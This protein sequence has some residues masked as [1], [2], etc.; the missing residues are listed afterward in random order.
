MTPLINIFP[1]E[2]FLSWHLF[3]PL[4]IL[5]L[6]LQKCYKNHRAPIFNLHPA[7]PNINLLY[8]HGIILKTKKL[9]FVQYY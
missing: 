5:M 4:F 9:T 8:N 1:R 7:S 2:K 3:F 6:D